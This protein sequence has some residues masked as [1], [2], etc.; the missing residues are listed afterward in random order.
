MN[1]KQCLCAALVAG[2]VLLSTVAL[3]GQATATASLQG[4]VTDK[5]QAVIKSAQVTITNTA[6][7]ATRTTTTND[8]GEYRVD[9]LPGIY[10]IKAT[11]AGFSTAEAKNVEVFIGRTATQN[12]ALNPGGVSETVE[13]T[14]A[15]PLVDQTKTDVSTNITP[16]QITNLPLIGRDIADL[17]YLAPGVKSA[18]SYDPT[19]NRY[20]ILSV[21]GQGGRNVNVTV[22]GVDNKDN[23]VGGPVMQLP[24]E[25][26]QEFQIS[27]QRFSAVNGRSAGAAINV[28]TKSG[29]NSYHGSAFGFF[30]EQAL[31]ADLKLPDPAN[32]ATISQAVPYSRQWFGGSFGGPIQKDKLFAF[33]AMERQREHTSLAESPAALTQLNLVTN[34]GAQPAAIV[35][36]PF[37]E[38]RINGR[39][40]WTINN[41]HS[42]YFSVS[43]QANNS[44]NDQSDGTMDLT[45]GNFTVNHLQVANLT[46]NSSFTP[47]LVNQLTLGWQ[48]WNNLIDSTTRAPLITFPDAQFGTNTN[49]PQN[50]IQR[51]WQFKDDVNKT[52]GQHT[53]RAG[54][55]YIWT[56]MMGGFFEFN[57]TLE[58]DFGA[59][60]SCILGVGPDAATPG[61]GPAAFPQGFATPGLIAGNNTGGG[62]SIAVG[63]PTFIIKDA[64][65][66][67]LYF[68]DDWKFSP[69][70]TINLGIRWDKDFDFVGGSKI[71]NSRTFQELQAAAPFSPLAASL[72]AKQATDYGK[73]FSPRVGLA[74]D[75]TGHGN[76]II[77]AGFGMYYDNT[78]Q[79]I[80]LFMEQQA[81][82]TI[83]QTAFSIS[84][85]DTVPG[86]G[87][88][89]DQWR[90]G[91]DPLPVIPPPSHDLTPGSIGRLM[92]PNYRTPVTEEFNGGYT[93]SINPKSVF[94]AEYVHVLGLHENKTINLDPNIP[95]DPSNITTLSRTGAP[96]GFFRPLDAAFSA[97][98]VP[99][100]GSLRDEQS[101]GRSRYDGLNISYRQRGFHNLDLMTNY[102]L[103]RSVGYDQDGGSFRYYPRDPQRPLSPFE[104]GPALN[105]ERHHL[106]VAA[107]GHLPWGLEISPIMQAGSARPYLA[108]AGTNQLNLGGG[109]AGAALVVPNNQPDNFTAFNGNKLGAVQCYYSG[110]CHV[111]SYNSLRGNPFFNLDARLA[112]NVKLGEGRNLQLI[113]QAFNLTNHA[114]Y[115]NNFGTSS[116]DPTTFRK[117]IGFINPT[118]TYLPR[119]FQ[120]EFGAR[121]SF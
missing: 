103:S 65:Q 57:P 67:G 9:V 19:K 107:T 3:W 63:D 95:V 108:D 60:P 33:F 61:C 105:D 119:S 104:F 85:N 30:R 54:V 102:T 40:D 16:E 28:I 79:N 18:D 71:A 52:I 10:S 46:L 97:A 90:F 99:V 45:E 59:N 76:H 48:Y 31:N 49:V 92:D 21:N 27:T 20:A 75:L 72:V 82:D 116:N 78:F 24:A 43:T 74:Y 88:A 86:T 73:G 36:R 120:G 84:G 12:F 118:S 62:M 80:P 87:I 4:T 64:K 81:N 11:A 115:G 117:A 111:V 34:L 47:T 29:S 38:N 69:R 55:D 17:A 35:P 93:W 8:A 1:R 39:L 101:I 15:A 50:S 22:N 37:F 5:T 14:S 6:T 66:L 77:R 114:N 32:N 44:L 98:G 91:V 51:K 25:A 42:A 113:F 112:K 56:P 89:L 96:G 2:L 53:L 13:V 100:L 7:G 58:I 26:V 106:T 70:L 110:N 121:F 109:S 41:K 83:F 23:T 94:E 68:Q